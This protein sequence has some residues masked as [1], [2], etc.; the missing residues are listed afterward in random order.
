MN[1]SHVF[2]PIVP[3][4]RWRVQCAECGFAHDSAAEAIGDA[5]AE[6]AATHD[7]RHTRYVVTEIAR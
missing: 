7:K 2:I 6:V 1:I 5:E 3:N 4:A